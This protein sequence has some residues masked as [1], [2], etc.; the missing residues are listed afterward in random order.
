MKKLLL[1]RHAKSSWSSDAVDDWHRPLNH[2]G[3]R[4]APRAGFWLKDRSRVPDLLITADALRA[5]ATAQAVAGTA[6]YTRELIVEPGLYHATPDDIIGV[7]NGVDDELARTVLLV[8]HNPGL[9]EL[10]RQLSGEDHRLVTT[11]LVELAVPIDRWRDLDLTVGASMV[12][13]WQPGER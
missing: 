13:S 1:L 5:R 4:D 9:E 7:L 3:E 11:A 12:D 8:G 10:V 2:R 6:G